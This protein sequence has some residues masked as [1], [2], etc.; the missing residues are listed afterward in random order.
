MIPRSDNNVILCA[1]HSHDLLIQESSIIKNV[2]MYQKKPK[3]NQTIPNHIYIYRWLQPSITKQTSFFPHY[4][5]QSK[6]FGF[7]SACSSTG[8]ET[9]LG[10]SSSSS[11]ELSSLL[12]LYYVSVGFSSSVHLALLYQI[13]NVESWKVAFYTS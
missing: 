2:S 9:L 11:E 10:L 7:F 13:M 1:N 12:E 5:I 8:Q 3:P 6:S 4:H